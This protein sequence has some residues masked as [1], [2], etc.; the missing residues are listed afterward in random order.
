MFAFALVALSSS[1]AS[2]DAIADRQAIMK[3][4]GKAVGSLVPMVKGEAPFDAA[5][6]AAAFAAINENVQKIDVATL[7]P[8]GSTQG[9]T[10][11]SPKIWEDMAGFQA[12]VDKYKADAAA[13][14][15]A[16]SAD[17]ATFQ[18]QFGAV[19][20][21]CGSCHEVYRIKKD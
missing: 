14:V 5:A 9:D 18:A 13:A 10:T 1:A 16:N 15:A 20:K 8:E 4:T 11:A 12:A 17:L 6:V 2:A 21:N 19:T 3:A 7:F